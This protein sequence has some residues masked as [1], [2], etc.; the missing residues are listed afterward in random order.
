[1][2]KPLVIV[3]SPAKARTIAGYL[4]KRLRGARERRPHSRPATR[5]EGT[6]GAPPRQG[7]DPRPSRRHRS[8]RPLRRGLRRARHQEEGR[9]RSEAGAQGRR[10]AHRRDR[11]GPRG[12]GHRLARARG[13]AAQGA[14]AAHGV[15]RDHAARDPRSARSTARSRHE[16]GRG[17]GRP[18]H[19][20][21]AGRV[22]DVAGVV[23]RVRSR[24]GRVGR[25]RA[26]RRGALDR[27]ARARPYGVP[28]RA[29][30]TTSKPTSSPTTRAFERRWSRS[31]AGASR[32]AATST[33]RP[34]RSPQ[35]PR[36]RAARRRRARPRW[37]TGCATPRSRSRRSRRSP[38]PSG[39]GRR[40]PR[41]PCSR[42]PA[43]SCATAPPAR[44]RS[45]SA[46]TSADT[47]PTCAPTSTNLSDQAITAAR[48]A[49]SRQYG[50]EY[51]PA[52][53]RVYRSKVKNAQEAHE[54][55]RPAGDEIRTP[56]A[57]ARRARRRRAA[58][59]RARVDPYGRVPDG[60]RARQQ[61]DVAHRGD[62]VGPVNGNRLA[63]RVPRRGQDVRLP[64][65]APRL[66]R[67]R[68]RGRRGRRTRRA[69]LQS[70]KGEAVACTG[71][72]SGRP[73]DQAARALH[74]G[75]P[76]EGARRARH[77]PAVDV[78]GGDR[79]DPG[80]QL[81]VEEGHRSGARVDRVRGHQPA[82]AA[83]RPPRRL[84]LH[85]DHGRGARRHRA[86]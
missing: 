9:R 46:S 20:R 76:R 16:A 40:S 12:R 18:A 58:A 51:L 72:D 5:Q 77:R 56:D 49:I 36:R 19:A 27:R 44:W 71:L 7:R 64:R 66:R 81:R 42:R 38:S 10:R 26:E 35:G 79:D 70:S 30:G 60:R 13:A 41:R 15:P 55:I 68:R 53:P 57:A 45:R 14:G 62:V 50:D 78:R 63:R 8:R 6:A 28:D 84:Q 1:M 48:T 67:R 3:E 24:A 2:A 29:G 34:A 33:P 61:D 11:R 37:R 22:G 25:T 69:C 86:R 65:V 75:E 80:A 23:A 83:F 73:R 59:L 31:T 32:R 85:G 82:R 17:A 74:R 4:G 43:A 52:E 47:S 21:P 39:P 54:A